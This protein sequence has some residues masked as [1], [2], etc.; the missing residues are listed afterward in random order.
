MK[1]FRYIIFVFFFVCFLFGCKKDSTI[2][3]I[4]VKDFVNQ[5]VIVD[6][7]DIESYKLILYNSDSTKEYINIDLDMIDDSEEYKLTTEGSHTISIK[8][9]DIKTEI[10]F[11]IIKSNLNYRFDYYLEEL[12]GTYK[13]DSSESLK[14]AYE[15]EFD[16]NDYKLKEFDGFTL[17]ERY[18]LVTEEDT[19]VYQFFYSRKQYALNVF[20]LIQIL[21]DFLMQLV[22][23]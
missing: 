14:S 15:I 19:N 12:D 4:Q 8:Y 5:T 9:N 16:F 6:E 3:Q 22:G 13:F 20:Y 11:S 17:Q 21:Y 23:L 10:S 7:L 18:E 1:R 2:I